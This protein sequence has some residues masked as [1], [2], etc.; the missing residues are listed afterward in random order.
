MKRMIIIVLS[1]VLVASL[2][3]GCMAVRPVDVVVGKGEPVAYEYTVGNYEKIRIEGYADVR[4]YSSPSDVVTLEIQPNLRD[5]CVVEVVGN[6]LVFRMKRTI[7]TNRAP[8]LT[9]STPVL[10]S[11]ASYGAGYF[12][13]YDEIIAD[14]FSLTV[15]GAGGGR[16]ELSV[17][18]L[19]VVISG[20]GGFDLSG[21]ADTA[22]IIMSGA[23]ALNALS[24]ETRETSV[25][26][27]G[28]GTVKVNCTER[29]KIDGSG[30]GTVEYKGSPSVDLV[31]SGVI[32]VRHAG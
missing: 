22:N 2:L 30:V 15:S 21:K 5:H 24:L 18:D 14:S 6:E 9:V 19:S 28:A 23:G 26:M 31:K 10:T 7:S 29:L 4:Y 11:M 13:A 12:T 1:L 16:A 32:T 17:K 3:S 25:I 27:S 20:A 8:V